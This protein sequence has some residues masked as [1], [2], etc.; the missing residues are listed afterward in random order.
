MLYWTAF[1]IGLFGSLHCLGMCGPLSAALPL[2]RQD[3][4]YQAGQLSIYHSGRI[5]TYGLLGLLIGLFGGGAALAGM[6]AELSI[7]LGVILL[8]AIPLGLNW[9]R[10]LLRRRSFQWLQRKLGQSMGQLMKKRGKTALFGLGMLNGLLPCGLVYLAI[11]GALSRFSPVHS[12]V[13]ML[14]FGL[15]TLPIL[16][17]S[18]LFAHYLRG[19]LRRVYRI[20]TPILV[21][22]VAILLILRGLQFA[23]PD[24]YGWWEKLQFLPMCHG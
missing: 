12:G 20:V 13:Y 2:Q 14:F 7:A 24:E 8:I 10:L 16:L 1:T 9:E 4:W 19:R 18:S 5:L 17:S 11:M 22:A 21:A 15:G 6:Q 3:R 23:L